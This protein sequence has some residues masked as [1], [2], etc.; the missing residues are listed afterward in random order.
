[1]L[2]CS[3]LFWHHCPRCNCVGTKILTEHALLAFELPELYLSAW[4]LAISQIPFCLQYERREKANNTKAQHRQDW[5]YFGARVKAYM[6]SHKDWDNEIWVTFL[7]HSVSTTQSQRMKKFGEL[8]QQIAYGKH[9]IAGRPSVGGNIMLI[10]KK[11][12]GC[13]I[14]GRS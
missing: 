12:I 7:S 6:W 1:M 8:V 11:P 5:K 13:E 3:I 10:C 14:G 2:P 4:I 9:W